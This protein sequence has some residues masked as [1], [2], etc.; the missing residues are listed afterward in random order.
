MCQSNA[1]QQYHQRDKSDDCV[2][3]QQSLDDGSDTLVP[4][5][6]A[7]DASTT[8]T[9]EQRQSQLS[10]DS[11]LNMSY[12]GHHSQSETLLDDCKTTSALMT[13]K[14]LNDALPFF[15]ETL[16]L[17]HEDIQKTLSA[18]MPLG[19]G[20]ESTVVSNS[21]GGNTT[22]DTE[23][24]DLR[25]IHRDINPMDFIDNVTGGVDVPSVHDDDVFV[26][27]D[28]FD[29][30]VEFPDLD[31]DGKSTL[32][33]ANSDM[34]ISHDVQLFHD[35]DESAQVSDVNGQQTGQQ[36]ITESQASNELYDI[37]DY[38]PEWAYPEG[39]IKVLVTGPWNIN[40]HYTVLFDSFPVPTTVVQT[41]VLRCYCPAHEVGLAT[42]Q[43]ACDGFVISNSCIF[44][45]KSPA[46]MEAGATSDGTTSVSATG[47]NDNLYK[48]NLYS[49]LE[50]IDERLQIKTEP[51]DN[52]S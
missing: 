5:L 16:E 20:S 45:Y 19:R 3:H 48:L 11:Y 34:D 32:L 40:S 46:T 30:F 13:A 49:R 47:S 29:M 17:S 39:G 4:K 1:N 24:D 27:L 52:V 6:E 28:A 14:E 26:N 22:I 7:M 8:I 25:I 33:H 42:L 31:L 37:T 44:E 50:C 36:P 35:T 10:T 15:H 21:G 2:D 12:A 41:G 9:I 38:S 43:V 23:A 51:A 18:N